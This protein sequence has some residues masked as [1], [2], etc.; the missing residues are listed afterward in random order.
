MREKGFPEIGKRLLSVRGERD[1]RGFSRHVNV[2]QQAISN[3]ERGNLP[4]SWSFLRKMIDDFNINV[5]WLITGQG[6]RDYRAGTPYASLSDNRPPGW[7]RVFVEQIAFDDTDK[8][9]LLLDIYFL[10]LAT[11]PADAKARLV[12]DLQSIV[13]AACL[14]VEQE[15][16]SAQERDVRLAVYDALARDDRRAAF[17]ALIAAGEQREKAERTRTMPGARRLYLAAL[18]LARLQGWPEDELEAARR[19]GR[20]YR[21]EGRWDEAER[22][23]RLAIS[24]FG[25]KGEE[26]DQ[27]GQSDGE[28]QGSR[29]TAV[30]R[31]RTLLGYGHVAKNRGEIATA[32]ERY[33]SALG[34]ALR[35]QDA[36]LRA[37][38]YLDLAC[39]SYREKEWQKM[40]DFVASGRA[41]AEQA[42]NRS[43]LNHFK[44]TEALVL[45][46]RGDLEAA[47]AFLRALLAQARE[48]GDATI[49]AVAAVNLAEVLIDRGE[50]EAAQELLLGSEADIEAHGNPRDL[51]F[52][53]LLQ[54]KLVA[55]KG[56]EGAARAWVS[57]CLRYAG[58]HGLTAEFEQRVAA[59]FGTGSGTVQLPAASKAG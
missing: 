4:A 26:G 7:P 56:E 6:Q 59:A 42:G 32:R 43:L 9:Q 11:E 22:F 3:Y 20:S 1:Q 57:E 58:E 51:A 15:S 45:S 12:A 18:T 46:E 35:S 37:E 16:A 36:G 31:A 54:A 47:E 49:L 24:T 2:S 29:Q 53:K 41:F 28:P 21:K 10:Y 44:L 14:K 17:T 55:A 13:E 48:E 40:Q 27:A 34:W 23:F 50:H 5:N 52:R 38:V 19:V 33:L 39:L 30:C 25:E 8:L